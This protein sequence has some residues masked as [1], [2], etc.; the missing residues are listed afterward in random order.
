MKTSDLQLGQLIND[1]ETRA[2]EKYE[3]KQAV[4]DRREM[5]SVKSMAWTLK[6]GVAAAAVGL[7][8][9]LLVGCCA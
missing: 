5:D 2:W 9:S 3:A 4:R 8:A 6:L 1:F 7:V